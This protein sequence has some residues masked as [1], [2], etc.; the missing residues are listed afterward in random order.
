MAYLLKKKGFT[1]ITLLEKN[2]RSG[3]KSLT[4]NYR[5]APQ[6]MG[7]VYLSPDYEENIIKLMKKYTG[8][9]LAHLPPASIRLGDLKL[10][11]P[12]KQYVIV[13][14]MRNFNTTNTTIA[15]MKLVHAMKSYIGL[16]ARLFGNYT[17]E[18]M[19]RPSRSVMHRI[20]GTFMDFL[21]RENLASL[22]PIFLASHTMQGYG[23]LDEISALYGLM[24][25][26]PKL[27]VG[28]LKRLQGATNTG[29]YMLKHGFQPLWEAIIDQEN[30]RVHYDVDIRLLYRNRRGSWLCTRDERECHFFRFVI[31]TP[32][33]KLSFRKF[34]P[35]RSD[36]RD[37]FSRTQVHYYSTS[38]VDSLNVKRGLTAIDYMFG[39]VLSKREHSVW[40]QRDSYA[41]LRGYAGPAYQNGTYPSGN[42]R[43]KTRTVVGYQY[44]KRKPRVGQLR[45]IMKA[46]LS[47]M[48]GTS[49]RIRKV[50]PWRY[51]P[52]FSPA[53]MNAGILWDILEMQGRHGMWYAGSSVIF[54]SVKSVV[55]YNEL[56]VRKMR[57][58]CG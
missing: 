23:H 42:D 11:I 22:Q 6:D 43:K 36:E 25:N 55:E 19:P 31:W 40:A 32:E 48:H 4:I 21:K 7:T 56:L 5:G 27:M 26:T 18:L 34:R 58:P 12:Y 35:A 16:H 50:E 53:D 13:E 9:N 14:S 3:G 38:L 10:S 17:G 39:N 51:F 45:R 2:S 30:L 46:T 1:D 28:L 47:E 49:I 29:L 33:L 15:G 52:R 44:G 57:P 20:R 54:E 8:D 37:I 24:W 41:A